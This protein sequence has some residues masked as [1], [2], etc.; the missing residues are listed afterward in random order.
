MLDALS[1]DTGGI[2]GRPELDPK[3]GNADEMGG[4]DRTLEGHTGRR[5]NP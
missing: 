2:R 3:L 4:G 1:W 5:P